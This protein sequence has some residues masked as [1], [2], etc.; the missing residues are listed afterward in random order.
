VFE[1]LSRIN[2]SC[3]PNAQYSW[4]EKEGKRRLYAVRDIQKGEEVTIDYVGV[5]VLQKDRKIHLEQL[6]GFMCMCE[7]CSDLNSMY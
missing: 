1:V 3:S 5:D 7:L 6:Y 2:H 4:N